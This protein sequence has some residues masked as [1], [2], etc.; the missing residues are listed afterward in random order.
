L[1]DGGYDL[2]MP[3]ANAL[4]VAQQ[5][6]QSNVVVV[7]GVGHSVVGADLSFCAPRA[8]RQWILGA[9]FPKTGQCPRVTPPVKTLTAFPKAAARTPQSTVAVAGKTVREGQAA[10]LQ[11]L[12]SG[13]SFHPTGLFGGKVVSRGGSGFTLSRYAVAPGVLVSG[14]LSAKFK[15][16]SFVVSGTVRISGPK[17]VAGS[18]HVTAGKL[19]GTLAGRRVSAAA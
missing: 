8:V 1:L 12:F 9:I 11:V 3:V 6:P 15:G 17:A 7:P 19:S 2:R 10:W 18:L 13:A 14:K 4:A 5:F 16:S